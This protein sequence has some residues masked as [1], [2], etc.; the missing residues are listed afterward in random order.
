MN[1]AAH[2]PSPSAALPA[3]PSTAPPYASTTTRDSRESAPG[4]A[5]TRTHDSCYSIG[6]RNSATTHIA[7]DG[8]NEREHEPGLTRPGP[9][10]ASPHIHMNLATHEPPPT[11]ALLDDHPSSLRNSP[12]TSHFQTPANASVT[13]NGTPHTSGPALW[14]PPRTW[15]IAPR[16]PSLP[17]RLHKPLWKAPRQN[18]N[19]S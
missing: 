19:A 5:P 2:E 17:N 3:T 15:L 16:H 8:E 6:L 18:P 11:D 13:M 10:L 7:S 4:D 12:N 1:L 9:K 14:A